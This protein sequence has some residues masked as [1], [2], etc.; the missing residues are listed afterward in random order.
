M[1]IY[2][3]HDRKADF[4]ISI[5]AQACDAAAVHAMRQL[6]ATADVPFSAVKD[7]E[8]L[9]IGSYNDMTGLCNGT[10]D[11]QYDCENEQRP[12]SICDL[13]VLYIDVKGSEPSDESED[14]VHLTE[15]DFD[16]AFFADGGNVDVSDAV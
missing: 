12:R 15:S 13:S 2:A 7:T 14:D 9:V 10:L 1:K 16:P 6:Y 5:F 8:L 4:I 3:V 11:G